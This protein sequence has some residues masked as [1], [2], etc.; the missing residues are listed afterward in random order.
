MQ[1]GVFA[2]LVQLLGLVGVMFYSAP[3]FAVIAR[4]SADQRTAPGAAA[5]KAPAA[6][7]AATRPLP[8][9]NPSPVL[10]GV[11]IP[12]AFAAVVLLLSLVIP[13]LINVLNRRSILAGT[14]SIRREAG[15]EGLSDVFTDDVLNHDTGKLAFGYVVQLGIRACITGFATVIAVGLNVLLGGSPVVLGAVVLFITA[16]ILPFPTASHVASW[17]DRQRELLALERQDALSALHD[18]QLR[19]RQR[20]REKSPAGKELEQ[21]ANQP[22]SADVST[23]VEDEVFSWLT[24]DAG[25]NDPRRASE[26]PGKKSET[27]GLESQPAGAVRTPSPAGKARTRTVDPADPPMSAMEELKL[28][29][30]PEPSFWS[31]RKV[32]SSLAVTLFINLPV[33]LFVTQK[34]YAEDPKL[35]G[36]AGW[37]FLAPFILIGALTFAAFVGRL[38]MALRYSWDDRTSRSRRLRRS[39]VK[40]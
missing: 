18:A 4:P 20:R 24:E 13:G 17:L 21:P 33:G 32:R 12:C 11:V 34:V 30:A 27:V 36:R 25:A 5:G 31:W 1:A 9:A 3:P 37:L 38:I 28:I 2:V 19:A 40:G 10:R 29:F 35:A 22:H 7:S 39:Q 14:W 23:R 26:S 8:R 15:N 6:G 16:T